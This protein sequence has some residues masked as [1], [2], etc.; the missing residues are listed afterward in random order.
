MG[1]TAKICLRSVWI[2]TDLNIDFVES[3]PDPTGFRREISRIQHLDAGGGLRKWHC[4]SRGLHRT[5]LRS[6]PGRSGRSAGAA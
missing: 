6:S 2:E 4:S 5:K 1:E 3:V